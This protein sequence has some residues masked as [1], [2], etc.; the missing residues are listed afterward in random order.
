MKHWEEIADDIKKTV[1]DNVSAH[2]ELTP[3]L[4]F[5]VNFERK[6]RSSGVPDKSCVSHFEGTAEEAAKVT[7]LLDQAGLVLI[8]KETFT[9]LHKTI[10]RQTEEIEALEC[11]I[12]RLLER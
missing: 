1:Q 8:S 12:K 4:T 9:A 3:L 7:S 2:P 10:R 6:Y 11:R 5:F